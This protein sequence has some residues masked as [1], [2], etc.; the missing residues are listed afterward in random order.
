MTSRYIFHYNNFMTSVQYLVSLFKKGASLG[1][2]ILFIFIVYL[3][4]VSVFVKVISKDRPKAK[5]DLIKQNRAAIYKQINNPANS[6]SPSGKLTVFFFRTTTCVFLGEGCS[7]NPDDGNRNFS[8]SILGNASK[9]LVVPYANP[10]ASGTYWA[11][12]KLQ[13]AGF[14]PKTYA[15]EGLGFASL[16]PIMNLWMIFRDVS[17][18]LLVLVLVSIGFMIMF[19][20]KINPQTVISAENALPKIVTSLILITFSFAIA[21]FLVDV[22]YILVIIG[23]ALISNNGSYYNVTDMQNKYLG[24]GIGTLFSSLFPMRSMD[25][26]SQLLM[27]GDAIMGVL[28]AEINTIV[29]VVAGG[30]F[31]FGAATPLIDLI[32][33]SG[34]SKILDNINV[35]GTSFGNL[36]QG[37]IAPLLLVVLYGLVGVLFL[38]HGAGLIL[39]IL[40][41]FTIIFLMF[42]IF[43]ILFRA[44][45][46]IL[47]LVIFSPLILLFEAVPGKS[48]FSYWLKS[49]FGELLC[50]PMVALLLSLGNVLTNTLSYP[51]DFWSPPFLANIDPNAFSFLLG[52]GIMFIIPDLIKFAKESLGAKPLP[53]NVGPGTFF[54]GAGTAMGGATGL[55]S[56][57]GS[58]KLGLGAFGLGGGTGFMGLGKKG[59]GPPL[60]V[61]VV[62]P[63]KGDPEQGK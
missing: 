30:L 52:M 33:S 2:K 38:I 59:E 1:K 18:L 3:A 62:T 24:G 34:L 63:E 60:K 15:A 22:M 23:I 39:G 37:I 12:T 7:D 6:K 20:M 40:I 35:L 41:F 53:F 8:K 16:K 55:L 5:N 50:F 47:I 32:P 46:Q 28:P 49:L 31:M 25:P 21:G 36:P 57:F 9:L 45:L 11:Y 14:V 48:T 19:R 29:R 56:Q 43:F 26:I 58:V 44:Y 27:A 54:A 4:I 17:Y 42:R 13:E 61:Q 51:G 10:P